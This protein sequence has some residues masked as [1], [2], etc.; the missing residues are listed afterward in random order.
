M[1]SIRT[2]IAAELPAQAREALAGLSGRVARNWPGP[3][4]RWASPENIHLTLRFLGDTDTRLVPALGA[5]LEEIAG[6]AAPFALGLG[7]MGCFPSAG[8][9]RVVWVGLDDPE[10]RLRLLQR[11]VERLVRSL[12]WA[13]EGRAFT[14]HLTLGRVR[15][16]GRPPSGAWMLDPEPLVFQ[17]GQ[18]RLI[19][20]RLKPAGAEY[21]TL[22]AAALSRV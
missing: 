11:Q 13:R 19:E 21:H 6:G 17:I 16:G 3:A 12:G 1:D 22:H 2:F 15:E 20:S 10:E 5:G 4:V 14:P 9:P 8:R 7:G 18:V